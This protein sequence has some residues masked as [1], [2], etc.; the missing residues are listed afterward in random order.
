MQKKALVVGGAVVLAGV[1]AMN[2]VP[3]NRTLGATDIASRT[4][5]APGEYDEFY[6]FLSGGYSGQ[7]SV[8]GIPSGRM[9][10]VI[11]VFSQDPETGYGYTEETKPLLMTSFGFQA[12]DDSHHPHLSQTNGSADG[13]WVFINGNNTPRIARVDL[14]YFET[15]ETLEIP[16]TGGN[17]GSSFV[18]QNTEYV[19]GATRFSIPAEKDADV[20]ISSFKDNFAGKISFIS[21][22]PDDGRM[23]LEFQLKVPAYNY[24]LARAGKGP[25]GDWVFF[26]TYN[27]EQAHTLLEIEASRA[28]KDFILAVNWKK[29]E[30]AARNGAGRRV[31]ADYYH[32]YYDPSVSMA[33]SERKTG[34]LQ[35]D[36]TEVPGAVFLLPTPKSPHG[37]DIDPSGELIVAGG[38]L[39]TVIP[40][41]SYSKMVAAIEAQDFEDTVNGIPVLRYTST[42]AGEVENP[43]L[44]PLH[45]EFDGRGYAY[46]S[47]YIS[48]EIVKWDLKTF[49]VVDRIEAFYSIGHLMIPRGDNVDPAGKYMIG[50]TKTARD[51]FLPTGPKQNHPAQLYDISGDKMVMLSDFPT[52]GEPHYAQAIEASRIKDQSKRIFSL[53]NNNHPRALK[54]T[55]DARV[56]REGNVVRVYMAHIRSHQRPDNIEGI[57]VGDTVIF[58]HT[59]VEQD[60]DVVHGFAIKGMGTA[61]VLVSPGQTKSHVW[62]PTRTGVYPFYCTAFCSALHQEMQGYVRVSPKGSNTPLVWRTG[63]EVG[64]AVNVNN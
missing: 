2:A 12:W 54:R 35:I 61:E 19:F 53:E 42:I 4:Y 38:K 23:N 15:R 36:P 5:V 56:E 50:M 29:V 51:R 9:L 55:E 6:G 57:M 11:P 59:N 41:H 26:T 31:D 34:V 64:G 52:I 14:E 32:N 33:V 39:A 8:W 20:P 37:V 17:H 40:V 60:W 7:L 25:S 27:T 47:V 28:D 22:R 13:R 16:N 63:N 43:G 62:V 24:D 45:T 21:V 30:D 18:T 46:T 3:G 58:H 49:E 1:L 44:G 48:S 10:K